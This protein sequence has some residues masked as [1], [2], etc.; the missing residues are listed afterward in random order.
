MHPP[1]GPLDGGV[2]TGNLRSALQR[3]TYI[4]DGSNGVIHRFGA[5]T[6]HG[7]RYALV[8]A[9]GPGADQFQPTLD[10]INAVHFR[11]S[12]NFLGKLDI[13][14][15]QGGL[16]NKIHHA[17]AWVEASNVMGIVSDCDQR[18]EVSVLIGYLVLTPSP[19]TG[20]IQ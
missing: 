18:D 13:S 19:H 20:S 7:F 17:A 8:I 6:Q 5:A 9:S 16:L 12:I 15:S 11:T 14:D 2:Y 1:Y 4:H 10:F 3:D